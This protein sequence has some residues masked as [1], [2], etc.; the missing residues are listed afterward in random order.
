[1]CYMI[2]YKYSLLFHMLVVLDLGLVFWNIWCQV[3]RAYMYKF[4]KK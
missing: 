1:M 4:S 3:S 2:A